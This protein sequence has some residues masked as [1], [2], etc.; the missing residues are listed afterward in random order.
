MHLRMTECSSK[1]VKNFGKFHFLTFVKMF[2]KAFLLLVMNLRIV[3][4]DLT[5]TAYILRV[6]PRTRL[7]PFVLENSRGR[8][9]I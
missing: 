8:K 6:L 4:K 2:S 5:K 9:K 7:A 3:W 1:K